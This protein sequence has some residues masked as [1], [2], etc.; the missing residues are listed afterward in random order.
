MSDLTE[1]LTPQ[2]E[3]ERLRLNRAFSEVFRTDAGKRVLFWL[4][5]QAAIYEDAFAGDQSNATNYTL[6]RQSNG[7]R[8][9]AKLDEIDPRF[10]PQLL[11][12][13]AELNAMDRAA[14]SRA[15]NSGE[16]DEDE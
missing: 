5:E 11:L 6:G 12:A 4:L 3:S 13:V 8:L 10:Y 15:A 14:A 2:Q 1:S 9:I 7:R 16:D